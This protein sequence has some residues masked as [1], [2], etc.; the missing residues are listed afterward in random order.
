VLGEEGRNLLRKAQLSDE[1]SG[2]RGS[3]WVRIR[4]DERT[5]LRS[6][7]V[8]LREVDDKWQLDY[9]IAPGG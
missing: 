4:G 3:A 8:G 2:A 7:L 6:E 1:G 5:P 9:Q